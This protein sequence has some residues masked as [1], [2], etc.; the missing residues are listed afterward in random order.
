MNRQINVGDFA[1]RVKS[2]SSQDVQRF[3]EISGDRNPVHLSQ[4]FASTTIFKQPIVHGFLIGS[5]ISELIANELPG[6]GSIYKSQSM[7]FL[8]PVYHDQLIR[9]RV[10]VIQIIREHNIYMLKTTISDENKSELIILSGEAVIKKI[11]K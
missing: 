1:E 6:P 9:V 4:E 5:I 11:D 8:A 3:A 7:N 10:E 2:F